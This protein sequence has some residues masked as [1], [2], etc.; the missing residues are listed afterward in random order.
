MHLNVTDRRFRRMEAPIQRARDDALYV[1]H[2]ALE[3]KD[4]APQTRTPTAIPATA[5][6]L[7]GTS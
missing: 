1:Q 3:D 2:A 7:R 4:G 5:D 6:A